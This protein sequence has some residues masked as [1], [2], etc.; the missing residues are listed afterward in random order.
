MPARDAVGWGG[1]AA[2]IAAVLVPIG[3]LGRLLP[4]P[5]L[6][7]FVTIG[8]IG[9]VTLIFAF[10][11]LGRVLVDE[12]GA[13]GFAVVIAGTVGAVLMVADGVVTAY[14]YPLLDAASVTELQGSPGLALVAVLGPLALFV[15]AVVLAVFSGR[16]QSLP[17]RAAW[18]ML[19]GALLG[20]LARLLS[21]PT[22]A[23]WL[24]LTAGLFYAI[25]LAWMGH[26]LWLYSPAP[27]G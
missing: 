27:D 1:L 25:G 16:S 11:G 9:L 5:Y 10:V 19:T 14:V 3:V 7:L 22:T 26:R 8:N 15:A 2:V 21:S 23:G 4:D 24:A 20:L 17:S 18:I 13:S 12:I 6:A